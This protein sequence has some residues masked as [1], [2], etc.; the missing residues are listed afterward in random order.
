MNNIAAAN[1]SLKDMSDSFKADP[2]KVEAIALCSAFMLTFVLIV[3]GN[4]LT[5]VLFAMNQSLKKKSLFLIINMAFADL[6]LGTVTLPIYIYEVGR[7]FKVWT[8]RTGEPLSNKA[9]YIF[10]L[11]TDTTFSQASI[12]SAVFIS[13]ERFYAINWPLK[14]RTLSMRAYRIVICMVW[15]L[16]ILISAVWS[17]S[18]S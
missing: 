12:I 14:H 8:N 13:C 9:L 4:L 1:T 7:E 11:F 5:I 3:I 18:N 6:I 17:A 10:F 16:A 2:S 15:I